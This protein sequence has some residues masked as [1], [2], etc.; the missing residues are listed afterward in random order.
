MESARESFKDYVR[1]LV[2]H[3]N[4]SRIGVGFYGDRTNPWYGINSV[5]Q[6]YKVGL[7]LTYV[8]DI[9][10]GMIDHAFDA[11]KRIFWG[12]DPEEDFLLGLGKL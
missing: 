4:N 3:M 12:G 11:M 7:N 5:D 10:N 8:T 1:F 9:T 6:I 2:Q